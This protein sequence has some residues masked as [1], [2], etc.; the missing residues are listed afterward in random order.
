MAI[1]ITPDDWLVL[2][3]VAVALVSLALAVLRRA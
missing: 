2:S 1:Y 3:G